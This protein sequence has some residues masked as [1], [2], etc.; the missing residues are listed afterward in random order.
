MGEEDGYKRHA[1]VSG[2]SPPKGDR[3]VDLNYQIAAPFMYGMDGWNT[4]CSQRRM[5]RG[6][7]KKERKGRQ[8]WK[9]KLSND[10]FD[11]MHGHYYIFFFLLHI[12]LFLHLLTC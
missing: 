10:Y 12:L 1:F 8:K 6:T 4:V 5:K 9:R 7:E 2:V 11:S 3:L